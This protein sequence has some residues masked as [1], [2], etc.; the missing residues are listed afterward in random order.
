MTH[1]LRQLLKKREGTASVEMAIVMPL[2]IILLFGIL[3]IGLMI[4]DYLGINQVARE[5]ARVAIVGSSMS[6][7]DA[8]ATTAAP[9]IDASNLQWDADFRAYNAGTASWSATGA[10]NTRCPSPL[11]RS[12][13]TESAGPPWRGWSSVSRTRLVS[14][15]PDSRCD[16]PAA[17]G[18]PR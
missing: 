9:T 18:S 13:A 15:P 11:A 14:G 6:V 1:P 7:I 2:L 8:R 10:P 17:V 5:A 12:A 3:E 4:K 16:P